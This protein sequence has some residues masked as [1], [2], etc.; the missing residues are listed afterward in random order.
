MLAHAEAVQKGRVF[1][2]P[3]IYLRVASQYMIW[4][5]NYL[6]GIVYAGGF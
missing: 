6:A 5:A 2:V 3:G 4:S 1:T